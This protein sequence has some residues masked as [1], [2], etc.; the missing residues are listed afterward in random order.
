MNKS[1]M[2][3][4]NNVT[5]YKCGY[6]VVLARPNVGKSTLVNY[7]TG[8]KIAITTNTAQTTRKQIKGILTEDDAQIVFIDTPG[9]HKPLNK[10]GEYL[11]EQSTS[12]IDD[13]DVILFLVDIT[14]KAGKGDIWIVENCIKKSKKPVIIVA[15]KIDLIKDEGKKEANI[16]SYKTLFDEN[17][18]IIKVSAKTGKNMQKLIET[19]KSYL[20]NSPKLYPDDIIT[21]Q[22]MRMIASEVIREKIILNTKDEI[23]HSVAVL[24]DEYKTENDIDKIKA[25]IFVSADSQ[26][27]II[28]GK[29]GS[30]L[31]KIG[32]DS[33]LELEEIIEG[34]VFLELF[35][36]VKKNW[37]KDKTALKLL[38]YEE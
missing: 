34:K 5:D 10:L 27:G 21:D 3:K 15:N 16:I 6:A 24:I 37:Q 20:P 35:V 33:R 18:P 7:I 26:K 29:N 17:L 28:I 12:A 8:Q 23:P 19:I 30:M 22:N 32:T 13:S 11:H 36:K 31:K 38:G 4:L 14:Q 2:P 1:N 9:V 25:T